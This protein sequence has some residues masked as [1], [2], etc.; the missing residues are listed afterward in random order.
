MMTVSMLMAIVSVFYIDKGP[1]KSD[2]CLTIDVE[3]RRFLTVGG[4]QET[5]V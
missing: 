1:L 2:M 4:I 3:D 5:L